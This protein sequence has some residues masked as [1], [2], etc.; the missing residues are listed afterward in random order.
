MRI[1]TLITAVV[2]AAAVAAFPTPAAAAPCVGDDTPV[3]I[4][5]APVARAAIVCLINQQRKAHH[6][7]ALRTNRSLNRQA[8]AYS[9]RMVAERFFAHVDPLGGT[10]D[11]RAKA[12]GYLK[13]AYEWALGENLAWGSGSRGLPASIVAQWMASPGHRENILDRTWTDVGTGVAAGNPLG[14][15]GGATYAV[16]FGERVRRTS[17]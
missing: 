2:S 4:S 5:Q 6:R 14:G 7:R 16:E 12:S 8:A 9:E 10:I 13:G 1:T 3:T 17:R 15:T 11:R